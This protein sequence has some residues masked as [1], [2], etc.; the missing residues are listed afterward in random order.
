MKQSSKKH[1]LGTAALYCRLSRDDNMDSESNSIQNQRKILQKAAKD[2]GYD[3]LHRSFRSWSA[4]KRKNSFCNR[5]WYRSLPAGFAAPTYGC[6]SPGRYRNRN[7]QRR[8]SYR[9]KSQGTGRS[10]RDNTHY[11]LH[12]RETN[13]RL[14]RMCPGTNTFRMKGSCQ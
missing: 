11:S 4:R 13:V 6:R 9:C 5:C 2:K 3:R 10:G 12:D 14:Q 1:E 7:H 8:D